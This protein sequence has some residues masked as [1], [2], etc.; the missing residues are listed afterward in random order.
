MTKSIPVALVIAVALAVGGCGG[1]NDSS[2]S[3]G[4]PY[5]ES[6]ENSEATASKP[7]KGETGSGT[8]IVSVGSASGAG[9]VLV[10]SQGFTLYF[11]EKDKGGK[12]ACYGPCAKI[13]PPLTGS[14]KAQGGA[15]AS[16]LGTTERSDGTTQVTYAGWPLYTYTGD[17]K[18]GEANGADIDSFGAEW[19]ALH[20]NGEEAG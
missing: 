19:Y 16:Q 11:F 8:A 5:G 12:S 1:G 3:G 18:P 17:T 4:G 6:A 9:K 13:W 14:G 10:D 7:A 20:P 15:M 2:N